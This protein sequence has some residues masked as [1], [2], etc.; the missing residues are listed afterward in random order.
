M[1]ARHQVAKV[2]ARVS[3]PPVHDLP[4][5][6]DEPGLNWDMWLGPAPLRKHREFRV[7]SA[8]QVRPFPDWRHY[9]EYG[10]GGIGDWGAHHFD[11][12]QWALDYDDGGPVEF[13]A[14]KARQQLWRPLA[15]DNG[16]GHAS[17]R[18]RHHVLRR[19]GE[20]YV[21][22]GKF[23]LWLDGQ[24]KAET[25]DSYSA[26]LKKLL[27]ADAMRSVSR[28]RPDFRLVEVQQTRGLPICDVEIGQRGDDLQPGEPGWHHHQRHASGIRKRNNSP[29]AP[30]T[31]VGSLANTAHRGSRYKI[32]GYLG[33]G[34]PR[35]MALP[36]RRSACTCFNLFRGYILH[37]PS[38]RIRV[39]PWL[40]FNSSATDKNCSRSAGPR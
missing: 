27:P 22:R 32:A 36:G 9:R 17:G 25:M 19:Q 35:K 4:A 15:Y 2:E 37:S 23:S 26:L 18:Q 28:Q 14:G 30:A 40:S 24:L 7:E 1:R 13:C 5:E 34:A 10:S 20:L 39:N 11:I 8:R 12:V 21:S 6:T 29:T 31:P 33:M 3:N 38:V 16:T